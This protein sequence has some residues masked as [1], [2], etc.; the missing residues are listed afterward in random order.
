MTFFYGSGGNKVENFLLKGVLRR[1]GELSDILLREGGIK[2]ERHFSTG[3]AFYMFLPITKYCC[4]TIPGTKYSVLF[5]TEGTG[6]CLG[7]AGPRYRNFCKI[8][9]LCRLEIMKEGK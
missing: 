1:G 8:C 7:G 6:I 2:D 5:F 9:F 3:L 4:I